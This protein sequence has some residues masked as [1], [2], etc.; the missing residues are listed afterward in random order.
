MRLCAALMLITLTFSLSLHAVPTSAARSDAPVVELTTEGDNGAAAPVDGIVCDNLRGTPLDRRDRL[1]VRL[2]AGFS[3]QDV[4]GTVSNPDRTTVD[5]DGRNNVGTVAAEKGRL[6]YYPPDEY[7]RRQEP[8]GLRDVDGPA[9]R[10]VLL[11][12]SARS[13]DGAGTHFAA[14]RIVLA[15][16]P[17]VMIHGINRGPD[18]WIPMVRA[19]ARLKGRNG[20]RLEIPAS[21]LDHF[22][23]A[24]YEGVSF[25]DRNR[26]P[27]YLYH[28]SGPV[29]IGA[30]LLGD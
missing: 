4:S 19:T 18:C 15:R 16:A 17:V 29:E 28:G 1:E 6:F 13:R 20:K 9:T 21:A 27:V 8:R 24:D 30:A 2:P 11:T 7:N 5:A 3:E 14:K 12:V 10:S 26:Y 25:R 23:P 22:A